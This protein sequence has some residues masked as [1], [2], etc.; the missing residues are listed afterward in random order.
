MRYFFCLLCCFQLT[1][2]FAQDRIAEKMAW[3]GK[4]N[5]T[6]N[7]FVHFDKNIYSNNEIVYFSGYLLKLDSSAASR[8]H[9]LSVA[10][11]RDADS[12]VVLQN[13]FLMKDGLAFGN[14]VLPDKILTGNYH[15]ITYTDLTLNDLPEL[16][17]KQPI[18]IKTA[19]EPSFIAS[20]KFL[21]E[22]KANDSQK[23]ILINVNSIEGRFLTKPITISYRYGN[24]SATKIADRSGQLLLTLPTQDDLMNPNISVK[25]KYE[26]DSSFINLAIPTTKNK[27]IVK[28]YPEGG[29]MVA[30]LAS[31][32]AWEVVDQQKLPLLLKAFL[33][34]N[35]KIVDTIE[36]NTYGIGKF[37][38]VPEA[39]S[40]YTV[41]LIHSALKDSTYL[42]P[43]ATNSGITIHVSEAVV[44]DTLK[45]VLRSNSP[46]QLILRVHNF[47]T[48]F[49]SV[50]FNMELAR[51]S[52]KIPLA[53]IPKGLVTITIS[54]NQDRPLAERMFFAHYSPQKQFDISSDK[55]V[56]SQREKITVKVKLKMPKENA[57]VSIACVQNSRLS[58]SN[59]QDISSFTYLTN[60]L[61][62]LPVQLNGNPLSDLSYMEQVLLVKGWRR[63]NWQDLLNAPEK[64]IPFKTDSLTFDGKLTHEEKKVEIKTIITFG[65]PRFLLIPVDS[66][67]N[68]HI[69]LSQLIEKP[70][71]RLWLL[72]NND[73][74]LKVKD[75]YLIKV[76][77]PYQV[78]NAKLAKRFNPEIPIIPSTI[79]N[80][81][82]LVLKNN[83]RSIRLKEVVIGAKKDGLNVNECGD[84]ICPFNIINC[85]NH[86]GY[87]ANTLPVLGREYIKYSGRPDKVK[88]SGCY[89][90][91]ESIFF[92]VKPIYL[93]KEFYLGDFQDPLEPAYFST[94]YWSYAHI[95]NGQTETEISFYSSDITGR[96][97]VV[98][99][100]ISN[101]DVVYGEHFFEVTSKASGDKR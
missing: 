67:G 31:T 48:C 47:Q 26:N 84:Y 54:D 64:T 65:S 81:K 60:E 80:N 93:N 17:F 58:P 72:L 88:Y 6:G 91:D 27:A 9:V 16:L 61:S 14:L 32:I 49:I 43:K 99:Q 71:T 13:K 96:F 21:N 5:S 78:M 37:R 36:T 40:N 73:D 39:N 85:I 11:I 76:N 77:D 57:I 2:V 63:Y 95:L 69:N 70:G 74:R 97:R 22:D 38:L 86:V 75:K 20:M 33:F 55:T 98:L 94:I 100:G 15:F 44:N 79:Q 35:N 19:R 52:F 28:F 59:L 92:Q 46:Q 12:T 42:I 8:H 1:S 30:G 7:L 62:Q 68:F 82:E 18:M 56:Y 41:K 53:D 34:K 89:I 87:Y 3:Y 66:T 50:P 23:K 25:V 83:E 51:Q 29:N 45:F 101:Q 10:L 4:S 90:A 24:L